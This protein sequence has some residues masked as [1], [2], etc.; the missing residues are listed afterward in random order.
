MVER[1]CKTLPKA[2]Y[3]LVSSNPRNVQMLHPKN[4]TKER[5]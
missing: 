2:M 3:L 4:L 5:R 1:A